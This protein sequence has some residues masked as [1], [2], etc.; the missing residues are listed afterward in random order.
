MHHVPDLFAASCIFDVPFS[1]L[2]KCWFTACVVEVLGFP[3]R[4]LP[5]A[6][7]SL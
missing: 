2:E 3:F 1:M 5:D 4:T 7:T 6:Q